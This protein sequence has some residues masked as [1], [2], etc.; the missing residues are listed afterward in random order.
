MGIGLYFGATDGTTG[1][2]LWRVKAD[3]SVN[4]VAD[5]RSGS[6]SSLPGNFTALNGELYFSAN[7]GSSSGEI[8]KVK[9][10]GSVVLVTGV[11]ASTPT[12]LENF[13]VF[14]GEL[15]FSAANGTPPFTANNHLWKLKADGSLVDLAVLNPTGF[16]TS[17]D[18]TAFNGE[19]Y[20][21]AKNT[22]GA[23]KELWKVKADGSVVRA[24]DINSGAGDSSPTGFTAFNGELNFFG[25]RRRD[26][27][28][29]LE[30]EGRRKC[31]A[32]RGSW[33]RALCTARI[34]YI[35]RRALFRGL[36]YDRHLRVEGQ[37][38]WHRGPGGQYQRRLPDQPVE[39]RC[40]Q[41]RAVFPAQ[42]RRLQSQT[43]EG[44]SRR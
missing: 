32:A 1:A 42:R 9:S 3:G 26:Q 16:A 15:Y 8:W 6:G 14:N 40:L 4:R 29:T 28:P 43:V 38:R 44:Q 34:H 17:P 36:R 33:E 2:E 10:D 27:C 21:Q 20:F 13:T 23:G 31:G 30:G 24:A 41:W 39:L 11:S 37:G 19:L 18:L 35:Q 25:E 7:S 5:I 22:D 12:G